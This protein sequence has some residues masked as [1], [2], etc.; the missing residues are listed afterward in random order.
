MDPQ[1]ILW[2]PYLASFDHPSI[3]VPALGFEI[4]HDIC[5]MFMCSFHQVLQ[6]YT[7]ACESINHFSYQFKSS[8]FILWGAICYTSNLL[9][10][11]VLKVS[12]LQRLQVSHF[13]DKVTSVACFSQVSQV[14]QRKHA[15]MMPMS[16]L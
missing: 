11:I 8:N 10:L 14:C 1:C 13:A 3:G 4:C 2:W 9:T 12:S 6:V 16:C 15:G 7:L 5:W